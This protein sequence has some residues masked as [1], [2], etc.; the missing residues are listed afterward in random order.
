[1]YDTKP[2]YI[3]L[4]DIIIN[5]TNKHGKID[6]KITVETTHRGKFK[7]ELTDRLYSQELTFLYNKKWELTGTQSNMNH[8]VRTYQLQ[9]VDY[10][11]LIPILRG[12]VKMLQANTP[13]T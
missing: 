5:D 3:H 8:L 1:M 12:L 7:L 9:P 2:P 4:S 6:L 10:D 11:A 13:R